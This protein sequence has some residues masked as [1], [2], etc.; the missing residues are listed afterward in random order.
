[1]SSRCQCVGKLKHSGNQKPVHIQNRGGAPS[2]IPSTRLSHILSV[3][4]SIH[5]TSLDSS[6]RKGSVCSHTVNDDLTAITKALW[7]LWCRTSLGF[8]LSISISPHLQLLQTW[9]SVC[10][11]RCR[12]INVGYCINALLWC[13]ADLPPNLPREFLLVLFVVLCV[14]SNY[15]CWSE[16]FTAVNYVGNRSNEWCSTLPRWRASSQSS[17]SV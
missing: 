13:L 12:T 6:P 17:F 8:L 14:I 10:L 4:Q 5:L 11:P 1:M 7:L 16:H 9:W 3:Q 15:S 2:H